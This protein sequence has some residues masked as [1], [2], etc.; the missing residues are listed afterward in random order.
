MSNVELKNKCMFFMRELVDIS[1]VLDSDKIARRHMGKI[2][3]STMRNQVKM[4]RNGYIISRWFHFIA[5]HN[6]A[7]NIHLC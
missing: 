6:N 3:C 1:K 2:I 4:F 7:I 5:E